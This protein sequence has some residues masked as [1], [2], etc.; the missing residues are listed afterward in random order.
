MVRELPASRT[1]TPV[2]NSLGDKEHGFSHLNMSP[3]QSSVEH[4][5]SG[6]CWFPPGMSVGFLDA[7]LGCH[8]PRHPGKCCSRKM[9]KEREEKEEGKK[10]KVSP[11]LC[12]VSPRPSVQSPPS[13]PLRMSLSVQI[14]PKPVTMRNLDFQNL[15]SPCCRP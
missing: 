6:S 12:P 5:G 9:R 10:K 7:P 1:E 3:C 8:H 4:E 15:P 2:Q 14:I 13:F 11:F